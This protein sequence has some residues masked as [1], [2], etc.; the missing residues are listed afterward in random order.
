MLPGPVVVLAMWHGRLT[1]SSPRAH[2]RPCREVVLHARTGS[3]SHVGLEHRSAD[4]RRSDTVGR[5]RLPAPGGARVLLGTA[6][7]S[8][9]P[10]PATHLAGTKN[11]VHGPCPRAASGRESEAS[12]DER[13]T[14][15]R[16]ST[17]Q[18]RRVDVG[19]V[20]AARRP[21]TGGSTRAERRRR[22]PRASVRARAGRG[23][24]RLPG[25][26]AVPRLPV[27]TAPGPRLQRGVCASAVADVV[28]EERQAGRVGPDVHREVRVQGRE[29]G[30]NRAGLA[31]V[32]ELSGTRP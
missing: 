31:G 23:R 26:A 9:G 5:L 22:R 24:R 19:Q 28:E 25:A 7:S 21:L 8:E 1:N 11:L 14:P 30:L 10:Y 29:V 27:S 16:V 13:M 15:L 20:D 18:G 4:Q 12:I 2:R 17:H 6:L 32:S 3:T